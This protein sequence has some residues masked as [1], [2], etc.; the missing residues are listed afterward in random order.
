VV[1]TVATGSP[2]ATAAGDAAGDATGEPSMVM[3]AESPPTG[4]SETAVDATTAGVG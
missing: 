4:V 2:V 3:A 1:E